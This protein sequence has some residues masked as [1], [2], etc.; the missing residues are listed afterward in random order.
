MSE[1]PAAADTAARQ[2]LEPAAE[3]AVRTRPRPARTPTS[4]PPF[5]R[6]SP[7]TACPR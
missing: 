5:W 6:T 4:S 2:Q 3:A 7:P 1:K